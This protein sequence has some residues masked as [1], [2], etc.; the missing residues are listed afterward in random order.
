[1]SF[2]NKN[3]ILLLFCLG[4]IFVLAVSFW[5]FT[6]KPKISTDEAI[7]IELARNFQT[8]GV[9]SIK[10]A[11]AD[12]Y[13]F[14]ERIQSTGYPVTIPLALFFE[15]FGYGLT[16]A[17]FYML[18]WIVA[19]LSFLLWLGIKW[20]GERNA[21]VAFFLVVT[22][23]SFYAN[24]RTVVGEIPGFL[25][26]LVGLY[27]LFSR[28]QR[29][30]AGFFFGLAVVSKLSVFGLIIPVLILVYLIEWRKFFQTLTP[31]AIGMLPAGLLWIFL[32]LN[33]PLL[34]STW[35]TLFH[36]YQNPYS[37]SIS[38]NVINNIIAIPHSTT[39]IYFG[40]LFI[41]IICAR[42][43]VENSRK[44]LYN[45][46]IIYGIAAFVY[47]LRSPGW[48]RYILI[49]ELLILF[50]LPHAL[51]LI[52][53]RLRDRY[54]RAL[55][56]GWLPAG[57]LVAL[58]V[59]QCVQMF[60]VSD[61]FY[62]DGAI[63][64]ATSINRNF[65]GKS[66]GVLNAVEVAVWLDTPERYLAMDLAGLPQI[67]LNPLLQEKLPEVVVS[68]IGQRF[69]VEGQEVVNSNYVIFGAVGSYTI[70]ELKHI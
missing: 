55:F 20:F 34:K 22:F 3:K 60:T 6:T 65:P 43:L 46:V 10:T 28:G 7:S 40:I 53:A 5:T 61:I 30:W 4:I 67:G 50:L 32:S 56:S 68:N 59:V 36:F 24:G 25:F 33:Q 19:T 15:L 44:T 64:A 42:F 51:T 70:Y 48:L 17:R 39:L 66:V 23:A 45:F 12:F 47:Y 63:R 35:I 54:P 58:I 52:F 62:S 37:S 57:V 69:L 18:V 29:L 38:S 14:G 2:L 27:F 9:L 31:I 1:M 8:H 16:Q 26:L 41:I 11:P 13:R 21:L 49:S